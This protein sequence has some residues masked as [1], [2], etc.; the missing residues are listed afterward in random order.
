[1]SARVFVESRQRAPVVVLVRLKSYAALL[2]CV[3]PGKSDVMLLRLGQSHARTNAKRDHADAYSSAGPA[4][5]ILAVTDFRN[6]GDRYFRHL[7]LAIY[8]RYLAGVE[9]Q[10]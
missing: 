7:R 5:N 8:E 9:V 4:V 3:V 6:R 1:M 10:L 2:T